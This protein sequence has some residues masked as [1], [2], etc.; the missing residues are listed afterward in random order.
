METHPGQE[1]I[2]APGS[3]GC[4][5]P[6]KGFGQ[7]LGAAELR[8]APNI[9]SGGRGAEPEG[10]AQWQQLGSEPEAVGAVF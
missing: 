4:Q 7:T 2:S 3:P 9:S 6:R 5:Q 10:R 8:C 1:G